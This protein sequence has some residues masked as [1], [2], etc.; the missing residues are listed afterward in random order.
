MTLKIR[1][2]MW[3]PVTNGKLLGRVRST[4]RINDAL[5]EQRAA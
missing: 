4:R 2:M 3:M 1:R 5:A